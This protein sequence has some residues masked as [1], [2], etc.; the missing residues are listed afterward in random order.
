MNTQVSWCFCPCLEVGAL[1]RS[2]E[3]IPACQHCWAGEAAPGLTQALG[4]FVFQSQ[5]LLALWCFGV[6]QP[7]C[8]MTSFKRGLRVSL[9]ILFPKMKAA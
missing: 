9:E 7:I 6:T 1:L 2:W 4:G 3:P 5:H 8:Q